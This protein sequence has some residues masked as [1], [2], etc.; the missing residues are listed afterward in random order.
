MRISDWSSDVCS[1]DLGF[2]AAPVAD[3]VVADR[4]LR[5]P[6]LRTMG[7]PPRPG[8]L[9]GLDVQGRD[10]GCCIPGDRKSVV[11][12]KS[13]SVRVDLGGRR[14]IKITKQKNNTCDKNKGQLILQAKE[15][16]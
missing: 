15:I 1:S 9:R 10:G 4:L 8:R 16:I 3:C 14:V 2:P 13:V 7:R 11:K 6:G 12:G 5:E